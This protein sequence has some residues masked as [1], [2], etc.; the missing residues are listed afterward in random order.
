[1]KVKKEREHKDASQDVKD[2][3]HAV[4]IAQGHPDPDEFVARA[5]AAY[6]GKEYTEEQKP[7]TPNAEG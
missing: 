5:V 1:M 6:E 3:L 7:N 2:I 4:A